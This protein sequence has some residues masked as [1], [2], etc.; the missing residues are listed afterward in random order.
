MNQLT[1]L[2]QDRL[3]DIDPCFW[4]RSSAGWA[5][6]ARTNEWRRAQDDARAAYSWW[7]QNADAETYAVY[8][9]AQ[10]RADRAQ[11]ELAASV[12][13]TRRATIS[14]AGAMS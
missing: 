13:S 10:D 11:D 3:V 6:L 7:R 2:L 8:L 14:A 4:H 5:G 9:A 1:P 12:S